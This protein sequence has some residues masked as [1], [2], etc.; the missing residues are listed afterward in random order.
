MNEQ[1]FTEYIRSNLEL[2]DRQMEQLCHRSKVLEIKRGD[3]LLRQGQTCTHRFF[4]E[5]GS[6]R[7]YFI[8][9]RGREHLLVFAVEGWF[10]MNVESVFFGKPS[11]YFIQAT[12]D[13]RIL[14]LNE[15]Q[16]QIL[17]EKDSTFAAF[18]K[19]LLY[20]HIQTLQRRITSLQSDTAEERYLH[21]VAT[22]PEIMLRI[23]QTMVASFLGIT[24]ESLSRIRK[25]LAHKNFTAR[26]RS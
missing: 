25:G 4:V 19:S 5:R 13:S 22:Y 3:F 14:L 17:E 26:I 21:F 1:H 8:D 16:V 23:P 24:P 12:E 7:E 10:L 9:E 11:S 2:N 18:N 20:E 15:Q 6:V